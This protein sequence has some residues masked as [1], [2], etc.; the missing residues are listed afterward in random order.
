PSLPPTIDPNSL[1]F[2]SPFYAPIFPNIGGI[3]DTAR[4][5]ASLGIGSGFAYPFS[6]EFKPTANATYT[7]VKGN[8]SIKMGADLVVD[9]IQTLNYTRANGVYGFSTKQ[10]GIGGVV[11][12]CGS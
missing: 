9:G 5:G 2:A 12:R 8:H 4:G 3:S 6:K 10:S 11:N 1:G 7:I